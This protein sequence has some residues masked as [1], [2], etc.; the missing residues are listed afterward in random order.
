MALEDDAR[1]FLG[2]HE[3]NLTVMG[4][5]LGTPDYIA[6]EQAADS[7]AIDGRADLYSLC[8]TLHYLLTGRPPYQEKNAMAKI[9]AHQQSPIPSLRISNADVPVWLDDLFQ[10]LLAKKP[11]D[12]PANAAEVV[13]SLSETSEATWNKTAIIEI[14]SVAFSKRIGNSRCIPPTAATSRTPAT[15]REPPPNGSEV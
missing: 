11:A 12:R 1:A 8:C 5:T 14:F 13:K 6:P 10:K 2:G 9:M 7:H 4:Q 3:Q 15:F